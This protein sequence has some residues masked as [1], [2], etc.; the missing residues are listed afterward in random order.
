ML[1]SILTATGL[2]KTAFGV[3][4]ISSAA[5]G[6]VIAWC[7]LAIATAV[8][9]GSGIN[10]LYIELISAAYVTFT[11][12][13]CRWLLKKLHLY[14][15]SKGQENSRLL[16]TIIFLF[17]LL[18]CYFCENLGIHSFFGAFV[19]GMASPKGGKFAHDLMPKLE[20]ITIELL[21]PLYFASS[22]MKT[23]LGAISGSYNGAVT[24]AIIVFGVALKVIPTSLTT[25]LVAKQ[26]WRFS[27]GI[28]VLMNTR[29]LV[30]IIALNVGLQLRV[31]SD[32]L[33]TMMVV[34][35]LAT[36]FMTAPA[37]YFIYQRSFNSEQYKREARFTE[38]RMVEVNEDFLVVDVKV[39]KSTDDIQISDALQMEETKG[40]GV[41]G[42]TT[43]I[44][45]G[46]DDENLL[47]VLG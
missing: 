36:T 33:F 40:S 32:R 46:P 8:A 28:G 31:F 2:I 47:H 34:M 13:F 24:V 18:N 29:G 7:A 11:M 1:A 17:L 43:E 23:N 26:G 39:S 35:A 30:E 45:N 37:L 5:L 9:S 6:D 41:S 3:V 21:I 15:V 4:G 19:A 12:T 38:V 42:K 44:S 22:R 20:L 25:A 10:G 27:L 14:F 16:V